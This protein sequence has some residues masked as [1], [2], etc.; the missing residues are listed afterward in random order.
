MLPHDI[1]VGVDIPEDLVDL[2]D[3]L[4][5]LELQ[6]P[7]PKR[8]SKTGKRTRPCRAPSSITKN[9]ILKNV[10]KR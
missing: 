9:I 4:E 2:L 10:T 1:V 3:D 8:E 6:E 7:V 5:R